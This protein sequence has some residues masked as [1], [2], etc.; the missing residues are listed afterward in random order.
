MSSLFESAPIVSTISAWTYQDKA[1]IRNMAVFE[2]LGEV[3]RQ[4]IRLHRNDTPVR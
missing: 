1:E 3:S 4:A 2:R